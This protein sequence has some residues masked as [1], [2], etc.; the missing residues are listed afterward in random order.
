MSDV[1]VIVIGGG[2]SGLS[3]GWWL[4][5]RGI[6]CEIWER[7]A[8]PGGKIGSRWADGYLTER[9]A[10]LI[11]N[12]RPE[13]G[14]MI[15]EAGLGDEKL[16]RS[17]RAEKRR[18]LL[19]EGRLEAVPSR[20]LGML[21]SP[22]WSWRAKLR[23]LAEPL[24]PRRSDGRPESVARFVSRR[25]GP[26]ILE[27]ALE[28]FVAGTL[29]ADATLAD[30]RATLPRLTALE[31]R[32]G[33]ITFGILAH[34]LLRRRETAVDESFSFRG[35]LSALVDGL[36]AS[37]APRIR[38]GTKA[39]KIAREGAL[40]RIEGQGA[41]GGLSPRTRHVV[42]SL[43]ASAAARLL[44][45][46]DEELGA[47]IDTIPYAPL[48]VVHMGFSRQQISHPLDGSGFLTPAS[49]G[50]SFN[51]T[52]WMSSLFPNRAPE[53]KVLL[54]SYVG[55]S[56]APQMVNWEQEMLVAAV[57]RDLRPII[58]LKGEPEWF[59]VDRHRQALPLYHG[60][61]QRRLATI[62]WRLQRLPGLHLAA[63][64]RGGVSVRDRILC[65][66]RL[67]EEIA[68]RPGREDGDSTPCFA[69]KVQPYG[70]GTIPTR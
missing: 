33:S 44:T 48:A 5:Q 36:A 34:R 4:T 46:L 68:R 24:I 66:A 8:R 21:R 58:G 29:A 43:P 26:E 53:G 63:N 49:A 9:A 38:T 54:S 17:R 67:A 65:G 11:V 57:C 35:G 14:R 45:P 40:W 70:H 10:S 37:L 56:R 51:G 7:D 32:H 55:G 2:I 15:H 23:M 62:G 16:P 25:L 3:V 42:L 41:G 1:E 50:I 31:E 61:Y 60:D 18:Y 6:D 30:A 64:Y 52:L 12:A 13:I 69:S 22:L 47:S 20:P 59:H 19:H 27:K 28:P 39:L